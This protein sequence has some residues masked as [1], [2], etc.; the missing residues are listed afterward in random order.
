M[1][2]S[3]EHFSFWLSLMTWCSHSQS[4]SAY[5]LFF[6]V[7][8]NAM[9]CLSSCRVLV[10]NSETTCMKVTQNNIVQLNR[11]QMNTHSHFNLFESTQNKCIILQVSV[12][13]TPE[14]GYPL[15]HLWTKLHRKT[16]KQHFLSL[17]PSVTTVPAPVQIMSVSLPI[18]SSTYFNL[19][20]G[21]SSQ[22]LAPASASS[23][24]T[25]LRFYPG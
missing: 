13:L 8:D 5:S 7:R 14:M 24:V 1:I 23:N 3:S 21:Q 18:R 10:C 12:P 11:N 22:S 16:I 25:R 9:F 17:Q 4:S 6:P 19:I 2:F 20:E 15:R